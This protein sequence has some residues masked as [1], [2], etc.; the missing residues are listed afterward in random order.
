MQGARTCAGRDGSTFEEILHIVIVVV[1][2]TAHREAFAVALQFASHVAVLAA[3]VS[4]DG[5]TTGGVPF[6]VGVTNTGSPGRA[7][8]FWLSDGFLN[9]ERSIPFLTLALPPVI[10]DKNRMR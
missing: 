6:A 7:S 3:I 9:R 8:S 5:E 10:R 4:L 2:Q 1:I